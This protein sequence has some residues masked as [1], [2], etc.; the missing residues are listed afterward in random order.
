M[1][2]VWLNLL[3]IGFYC[4]YSGMGNHKYILMSEIK[5]SLKQISSLGSCVFRN[6]LCSN[7][8]FYS[9]NMDHTFIGTH[10]RETWSI[11]LVKNFIIGNLFFF[12]YPKPICLIRCAYTYITHAAGC[13]LDGGIKYF[14]ATLFSGMN[15]FWAPQG[16]CLARLFMCAA[17]KSY[18][19]VGIFFR[20]V[21]F[22]CFFSHN[23]DVV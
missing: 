13:I 17:R 23:N 4:S 20:M 3:S 21:E 11:Q 8:R 14:R 5:F 19:N 9:I 2:K 6:D 1:S 22:F 18:F 10:Y 16:H 15:G 12:L 7:T